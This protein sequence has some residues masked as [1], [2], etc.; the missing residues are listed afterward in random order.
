[1]SLFGPPELR[2][3]SRAGVVL[4][5]GRTRLLVVVAGWGRLTL[6]H[7]TPDGIVRR[8][9]KGFFG[10]ERTFAVDVLPPC[11]LAVEVAN[12]FGHD[13]AATR[14]AADLAGVA[15]LP[16]PLLQP[17]PAIPAAPSA[18]RPRLPAADPRPP[19]PPQLG[20]PRVALGHIS[21]KEFGGG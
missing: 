7:S 17:L 15:A 16:P 2:S 1:M 19:P 8:R 20:A 5:G 21:I 12:P 14:F 6:V 18:A 11:E 4:D 10:G 9:R 3:V 13:S